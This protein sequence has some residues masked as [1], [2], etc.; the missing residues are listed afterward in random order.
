VN[1]LLVLAV[2]L[3]AASAARAQSV[4]DLQRMIKE[5]DDRIEELNRR[6]QTLEKDRARPGEDDEE[7]NRALERALVQQGGMLLRAGAGEIEPQLSYAHWDKSRSALRHVGEAA[8]VFRA[9]LGW[10][11]QFQARV[12]YVHVS[13][14]AGSATGFGDID[15][16]LS[17]Q[18]VREAGPVPSLVASVG[19]LSRTGDDQFGAEVPTGGGFNVLQAGATALKRQDPFV[20]YAGLSYAWPR[21]RRIAG[22]ELEPGDTLGLRLGS[23]LAA[24]PGA[25]VNVGLNLGF[26][27]AARR[28]GERVPDSDT[29]LGTL[30]VGFGTVLTRSA[31][32]NLSGDFRVT[33][34]VPNFRLNASLPIRF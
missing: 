32:V 20:H 23:I 26:V 7:M 8:L 22:T 33:G 15:L 29:V 1:R 27:R 3:A 19:W 11:S 5:R 18:F 30:Q 34:N 24:S 4:D 2:A 21:S 13:T 31:M 9:G 16:S 6:I 10:E 25:S 17:R 12:P 14:A 28:D